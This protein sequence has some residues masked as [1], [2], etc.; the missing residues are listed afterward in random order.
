MTCLRSGSLSGYPS[1]A[2]AVACVLWCVAAS[3]VAD[4]GQP[5]AAGHRQG[6]LS[7]GISGDRQSCRME[8]D[9]NRSTHLPTRRCRRS[10]RAKVAPRSPNRKDLD[11][12]AAYLA[13]LLDARLSSH[14]VR[15]SHGARASEYFSDHEPDKWDRGA[16]LFPVAA[17]SLRQLYWNC[18]P[19]NTRCRRSNCAKR[20]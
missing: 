3:A 12:V 13:M 8:V 20:R 1:M 15:T 17:S 5:D 9:T 2:V 11:G 10:L 7:I 4:A 19:D 14:P 18:R 16:Q 6:R